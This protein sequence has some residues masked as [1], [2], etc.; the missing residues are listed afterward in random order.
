MQRIMRPASMNTRSVLSFLRAWAADPGGVGAVTPSGPA[1]AELMAREITPRCG[2]VVELG[3]GTGVFTDA[4]LAR[5]VRE[6]DLT[7]IESHTGFARLLQARFPEARVLEMDASRLRQQSLFENAPVGAVL[8]G[9][10]LLNMPLA[11]I[12]AIL[13]GAFRHLRVDGAFYQFTYGPRCPVPNACMER[14]ELKANWV[15]H[16]LLNVPPATVYR[17][18]KRKPLNHTFV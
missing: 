15:G 8:S 1:L 4:L 16:A 14:L 18:T 12:F 11:K 6:E 5:G 13:T 2:P 3:P 10:P 17:I 9:L 7:L